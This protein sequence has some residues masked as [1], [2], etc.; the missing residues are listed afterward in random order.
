MTIMQ[1]ILLAATAFFA[2][3][4]YEH[5]QG[6]QD[7]DAN[8]HSMLEQIDI[9]ALVDEADKAYDAGRLL[10]ARELL[11]KAYAHDSSIPEL[12]NRLGFVLSAMGNHDEAL[13]LYNESLRLRE[14]DVTHL[15]IASQ[16]R[17][18]GRLDE[19]QDHY[20]RA[21]ELDANYEVTYFNYANLLVEMGEFDQAKAMYQKALEIAP[22]LEAAKEELEK[23]DGR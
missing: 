14:E 5:M 23:L 2:Y 13:K 17:A 18:L 8:E 21:I 1:I 12:A 3:K 16:L 10:E 7:T 9:D 15:A 19:S 11:Q 4:V 22:D 20:R 6:L